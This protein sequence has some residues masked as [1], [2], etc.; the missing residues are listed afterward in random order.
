MAMPMRLA[1]TA[2]FNVRGAGAEMLVFR[3]IE[4]GCHF[5]VLLREWFLWRG[6]FVR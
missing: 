4:G 1:R 5:E 3:D 2:D 6:E